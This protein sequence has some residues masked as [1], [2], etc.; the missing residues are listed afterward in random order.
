LKTIIFDVGYYTAS[1]RQARRSVGEKLSEPKGPEALRF[2]WAILFAGGF[3]V[4][5]VRR[6]V[7]RF[8]VFGRSVIGE[9]RLLF[10]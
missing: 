7:A 4:C 10:M 5:A 2:R 8:E 1:G 9:D 3:L 6:F